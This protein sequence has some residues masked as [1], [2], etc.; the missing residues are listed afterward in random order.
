MHLGLF[1]ESRTPGE[2]LPSERA[3]KTAVAGFPPGSTRIPR[4]DALRRARSSHD[5]VRA[6][7]FEV[8]T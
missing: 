3:H 2:L 1:G 6:E 7:G 8:I 5:G 4:V